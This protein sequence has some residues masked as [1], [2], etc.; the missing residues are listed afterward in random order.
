MRKLDLQRALAGAGAA[1][2]NFQY[3]PGA[4]NHLGAE[5]FFKITLLHGRQGAIDHDEA[6][7]LLPNAS[8]DVV[9]LAGAD[10]GRRSNLRE[11]HGFVP[12]HVKVDGA[13]EALSL[14][15]SGT[16]IAH[17][18]PS[19]HALAGDLGGAHGGAFGE[20]WPHHEGF[21]VFRRRPLGVVPGRGLG[22]SLSGVCFGQARSASARITGGVFPRP[23]PPARTSRSACLA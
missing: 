13:G 11:H 21:G 4:V 10:E 18:F 16:G 7:V 22:G 23:L 5:G 17:E 6:D 14:Q 19:V 1:A 2:E 12:N 9:H 8:G 3:Q 20:V 15:N